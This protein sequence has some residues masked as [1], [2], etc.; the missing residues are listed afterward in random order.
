MWSAMHAPADQHHKSRLDTG[1]EQ[2][3]PPK[4]QNADP[5]RCQHWS[6]EEEDEEDE[7]DRHTLMHELSDL[8][9]K[10]PHR[11]YGLGSRTLSAVH[12][13]CQDIRVIFVF[14]ILSG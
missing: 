6:E 13:P 14:S 8:N 3:I 2:P 10:R 11:V 5:D 12:C 7:A 4:N 1:A 9:G